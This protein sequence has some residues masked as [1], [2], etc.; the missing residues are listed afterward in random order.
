MMVV[1]GILAMHD[2]VFKIYGSLR[3]RCW[4]KR[5]RRLQKKCSQK[6]KGEQAEQH[7]TI[8]ESIERSFAR[9]KGLGP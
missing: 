2:E 1:I 8:L 9:R 3:G 7:K 4:A 5:H 6:N